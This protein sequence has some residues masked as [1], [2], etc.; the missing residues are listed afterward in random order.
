[1]GIL[2]VQQPIAACPKCH[3]SFNYDEYERLKPRHAFSREDGVMVTVRECDVCAGNVEM[4]AFEE[5][6][7]SKLWRRWD[8]YQK[9]HPNTNRT[10]ELLV[11]K[12]EMAE[13]EAR[14]RSTV[15]LGRAGRAVWLL[16]GL[17]VAFAAALFWRVFL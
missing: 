9:C 14:M 17:I 15:A 2:A 3:T 12:T 7:R 5:I 4:A 10:P 16:V 1:M 8:M 13:R 11:S 6:D